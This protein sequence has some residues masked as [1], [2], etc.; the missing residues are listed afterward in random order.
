MR[1]AIHARIVP[2]CLDFY[3]EG[4]IAV[5]DILYGVIEGESVAKIQNAKG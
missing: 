2:L 3:G 5:D 4:R 1:D